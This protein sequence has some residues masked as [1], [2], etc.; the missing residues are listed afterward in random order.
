MQVKSTRTTSPVEPEP[1]LKSAG[2]DPRITGEG[3]KWNLVLDV[4]SKDFPA[5][6]AVQE[7]LRSGALARGEGLLVAVESGT[8]PADEAGR[9]FRGAS[10]RPGV[11]RDRQLVRNDNRIRQRPA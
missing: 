7:Y 10:L 5:L 9:V 8:A 1:A 2:A 11:L 6:I 4:K 3:G